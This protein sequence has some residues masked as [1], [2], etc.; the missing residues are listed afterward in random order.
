MIDD[1]QRAGKDI[2]F[3]TVSQFLLLAGNLQGEPTVDYIET[4]RV[5]VQQ[6]VFRGSGRFPS[7]GTLHPQSA[8]GS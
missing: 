2:A 7:F 3:S 5:I 8:T 1:L 4:S 6:F